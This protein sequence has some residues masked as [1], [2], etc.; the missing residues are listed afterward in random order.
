MGV[1]DRFRRL[2]AA[3]AIVVAA[4]PW[5]APAAA[6]GAAAFYRGKTVSIVVGYGPGGGYDTYARLLAPHL[7]R[8]IGATVIVEN[9]PGGGSLTALNQVADAAPDGRV[10]ALVNGQA[11]VLGQFTGREG[12]RYDLTAM[13]WLGRVAAEDYVLLVG[14]PAPYRTFADLAA[15]PRP[16]R[17]A[18]A[19]KTDGI[20][21]GAAVL[22][23][24]LELS[25]KIVI[26]YR[27]S[28]ESAAAVI[29]GEADAMTISVSSGAR[30]A[31]GGDMVPVATLG[32]ARSDYFGG[33]VP[34]VFE[35]VTLADE[36]AWWL[37]FHAKIR[38]VARSLVTAP[39]VP[40]DRVAF[41]RAAFADVLTDPAF[42]AEAEAR[43]RHVDYLD[44]EALERLVADVLAGTEPGRLAAVR[45]VLLETYF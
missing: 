43:K 21:D 44:A 42:V 12:V 5:S 33:T 19:G 4:T 40:P 38:A 1:V 23:R 25:C 8:R 15:S 20:S 29:R 6:E 36:R 35:Q 3:L 16:I 30:Y 24:A 41:L 2:V 27:G 11:A 39:G 37:D 22:C 31:K 18:A 7:E 32:R 45:A 14:K 34:T 26:G 10:I 13:V 17:F 9:R 28:R